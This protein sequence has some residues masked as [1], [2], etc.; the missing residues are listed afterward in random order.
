MFHPEAFLFDLNGTMIND[1]HY[2]LRVWHRV[3]KELG[4]S[5]TEEEVKHQ[6]YG[7]NQDL[8]IRVFG[9]GRFSHEEMEEISIKKE[10]FYQELYMP[11]LELLPGLFDLLNAGKEGGI[12]MAIGS[13]AIPF[14]INF[15]L[16]NLH[17]R[18]YFKAVVSAHDV[19]NSKPHPETFLKAAELLGVS[20][21][22]CL[23]FEDSPKGLESAYRAGMKC[24][25]LTTMHS[26]KEFPDFPNII[27]FVK[28][29][30]DPVCKTLILH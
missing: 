18:D 24:L 20:P 25:V 13:A 16:D 12:K 8:L 30:N 10:E 9:A 15:V 1:M 3:I 26:E 11:H 5:L 29:Y 21:R 17:I 14:N 28:D 22:N 4:G 2:H 19:E 6:M 23:V 7:K 27:G